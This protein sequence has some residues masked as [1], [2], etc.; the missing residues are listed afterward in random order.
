MAKKTEKL[1]YLHE[2]VMQDVK[3]IYRS[4]RKLRG[5][6]K[7]LLSVEAAVCK[8]DES[9]PVRIVFVRN[10]NNRKDWLVLVTTDLSITE[11]VVIR[12]YGKR[13]GS[14]VLYARVICAWRRIAAHSHTML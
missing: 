9:L 14:E 7:Y 12:I 11:A 10:R 1:H 6:S 3:A 4:H 13:W 8:G 5:C 2:C